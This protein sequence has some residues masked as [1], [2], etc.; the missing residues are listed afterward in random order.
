MLELVAVPGIFGFGAEIADCWIEEY[1]TGFL[2]GVVGTEVRV[3]VGIVNV[4]SLDTNFIFSMQ[5][6]LD[7]IYLI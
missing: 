4:P 5:S 2:D 1:V 3:T 7:E 6:F